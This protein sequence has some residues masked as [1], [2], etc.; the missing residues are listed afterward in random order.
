MATVDDSDRAHASAFVDHAP[1]GV[2]FLRPME[3][4][5]ALLTVAIPLV[6]FKVWF[7]ILLLTYAPTRDGMVWIAAT[8]WPLV[9]VIG[10]L[11]YPGVAT[12]RL[13]RAR[14]RREQL[15]R[16]EFMV[17][18]SRPARLDRPAEA[19]GGAQCSALWETVSRL[20]GGG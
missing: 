17:V 11:I 1:Q 13:L 6:V 18:P 14:S 15:R 7:A 8:H 16:S 3:S 2:N 9:I 20:E 5:G 10:L 19:E 12:F 4:K